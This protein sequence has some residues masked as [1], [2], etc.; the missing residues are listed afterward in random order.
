MRNSYASPYRVFFLSFF[1]FFFCSLIFSAK[2]K[3]ETI[4][5]Y[6]TADAEIYSGTENTNYGS[7]NIVEVG[8][9]TF[10]GHSRFSYFKFDISG[11]PAGSTIDSAFLAVYLKQCDGSPISINV[12]PISND[13]T[14][15]GITWKNAPSPLTSPVGTTAVSC[16]SYK[17]WS[18][19]AIQIVQGWMQGQP[20]YGLGLFSESQE[21]YLRT[22]YSREY[23]VEESQPKLF[24]TYTLPDLPV[25]DKTTPPDT[26]I[27][28]DDWTPD[29]Q[30]PSGDV[31]AAD[32]PGNSGSNEP[33]DSTGTN[34]E[35][36]PIFDITIPED[37]W[38]SIPLLPPLAESM[39]LSI[40][41][42]LTLLCCCLL[43]ILLLLII[44]WVMRKMRSK[45]SNSQQ[46]IEVIVNTVPV[47]TTESSSEKPEVEKIETK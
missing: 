31:P 39:G 13:W 27:P 8:H 3:A 18:L 15:N 47:A 9:S 32:Q 29:N 44:F 6:P 19:N 12:K 4:T 14:E 23:G 35:E 26:T 43:I 17:G 25:I 20:N 37:D 36:I 21:S 10:N 16:N 30:P 22:F 38:Q 5:L 2:S 33:N 28:E 40:L 42:C 34:D 1:V 24:I 7:Y 41:P 45:K 46:P 11:I